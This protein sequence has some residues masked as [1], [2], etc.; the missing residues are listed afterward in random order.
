MGSTFVVGSVPPPN[1]AL[2]DRARSHGCEVTTYKR[3][4]SNKVDTALVCRAMRFILTRK[5]STL[6]LV[7]GDSDYCSLIK[8]AKE[9]DWKIE[10]WFWDG[11]SFPQ[12]CLVNLKI[13]RLIYRWIITTSLLHISQDLISKYT[14]E[15][16]GNIIKDWHYRNDALK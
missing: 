9:E 16:S 2:W 3:N 12:E 13:F 11:S 6:L 4:A 5:H 14:L 7:A 1:D 15:I 8:E 10:T